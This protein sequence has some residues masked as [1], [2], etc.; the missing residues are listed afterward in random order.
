MANTVRLHRVLRAAPERLYR[1]FLD[2]EAMSKWLPPYGFTCK[3]DHADARVGVES[4]SRYLASRRCA[5]TPGRSIAGPGHKTAKTTPCKGERGAE[6]APV[7]VG[8]SF[9]PPCR[10]AGRPGV[11]VAET[12]LTQAN[13]AIYSA[14]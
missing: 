13:P 14:Q 10:L 8:E 9:C 7:R 4:I 6:P 12:E 5:D 2:R 3:V 11:L 1:A